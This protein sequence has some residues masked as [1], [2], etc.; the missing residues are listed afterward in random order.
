MIYIIVQIPQSCFVPWTN[1]ATIRSS[2]IP[3]LNLLSRTFIVPG[4]H[5]VLTCRLA[6]VPQR[7]TLVSSTVG[8]FP[9][10]LPLPLPLPRF[11]A[12]RSHLPTCYGRRQRWQRRKQRRRWARSTPLLPTTL[13]M[14]GRI[15]S[16]AVHG[17]VLGWDSTGRART[18]ERSVT[19]HVLLSHQ[20][21]PMLSLAIL[22][23]SAAACSWS[24][25][26]PSLLLH[27]SRAASSRALCGEHVDNQ[28]A[29]FIITST[30]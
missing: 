1:T 16:H 2:Y 10:V 26:R 23:P 4:L 9:C 25:A 6:V 30:A 20:T 22:L 15:G 8:C 28:D 11:I 29:T 13:G 24:S 7:D 3:E 27:I 5:L 17:S 18:L 21:V 12:P 14:R 19:E